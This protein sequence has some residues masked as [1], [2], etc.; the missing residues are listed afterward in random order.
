MWGYLSLLPAFLALWG[1]AGVW[2]VFALAV[3]NGTV[4]L[5]KGFPYISICGSYPPQSCI[6]SQLLNMGAAMAAWICIL[7]Y[8]QLRDWGVGRRPNQLILW[9]GLLC[10]LGTSIVGNF[11]EKNQKPTHLVGAFLSFFVGILYFWLQ[12]FFCWRMKSLPQPGAPWIG[13]LRLGLCS[14]CSILIVA[15][16]LAGAWAGGGGGAISHGA[17]PFS[18]SRAPA[19]RHRACLRVSIWS[20][21]PTLDWGCWVGNPICSSSWFPNFLVPPFPHLSNMGSA[22]TGW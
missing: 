19:L 13:P 2:T 18:A 1:T 7:R 11:Q 8:H 22:R 15:S 20:R 16:I 6:F 17:G 3:E 14:V 5:T 10:A 9:T 4:N 12:L 21:V